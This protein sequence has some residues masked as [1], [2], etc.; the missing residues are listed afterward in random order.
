MTK[1]EVKRE[2]KDQEGDPMVKMFVPDYPCPGDEEPGRP[3]PSPKVGAVALSPDGEEETRL[4]LTE[5]VADS[6]YGQ[7]GH[8]VARPPGERR[9]GRDVEQ[10]GDG[11]GERP[12]HAAV[13]HPDDPGRHEPHPRGDQQDGDQQARREQHGKAH[14]GAARIEHR[15]V[16]EVRNQ[17]P[18]VR[19]ELA[20]GRAEAGRDD[21]RQL[22]IFPKR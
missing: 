15:E 5:A 3:L 12:G 17:L 11:D 8:Q 7:L 13:E 14:P 18:R 1:E 19:D 4:S 2:H 9:G 22:L 6:P 10:R 21:Y 16:R 20:E